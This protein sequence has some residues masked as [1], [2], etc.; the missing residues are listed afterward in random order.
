MPAGAL[1]PVLTSVVME[2]SGST[3]LTAPVGSPESRLWVACS[4]TSSRPWW[5]KAMS[6]MLVNPVATTWVSAPGTIR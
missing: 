4:R 3:R 2:P 1:R 5:S 6:M